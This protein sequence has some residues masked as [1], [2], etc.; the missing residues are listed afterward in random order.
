MSVFAAQPSTFGLF[1]YTRHQCTSTSE[2]PPAYAARSQA[3]LSIPSLRRVSFPSF[4]LHPVKR[5]FSTS[6]PSV[7][8]TEIPMP[9]TVPTTSQSNDTPTPT[10]STHQTASSSSLLSLDGTTEAPPP[11]YSPIRVPKPSVQPPAYEVQTSLPDPA[12]RMS[13]PHYAAGYHVGFLGESWAGATSAIESH[14]W[15]QEEGI[16]G[17]DEMEESG[18][19]CGSWWRSRS[20]NM[21]WVAYY[22][23]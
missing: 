12:Q 7:Q 11:V 9:N 21:P 1:S 18:Y 23:F 3:T 22:V 19:C 15:K 17:E 8:A 2:R 6:P 5:I 4:L 16:E 10:L 20:P 14:R 13:N